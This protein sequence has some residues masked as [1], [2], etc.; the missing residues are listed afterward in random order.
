MVLKWREKK[1]DAQATSLYF[2]QSVFA[3]VS[4]DTILSPPH[5]Y[6]PY[7]SHISFSL[8]FE[9][10]V[11]AYSQICCVDSGQRFVKRIIMSYLWPC[12]FYEAL[13]IVQLNCVHIALLHT[14]L[15]LG[16]YRLIVHLFPMQFARPILIRIHSSKRYIRKHFQGKFIFSRFRCTSFFTNALH[17]SQNVN[18]FACID[19]GMHYFNEVSSI[20]FAWFQFY[21]NG[22]GV[23]TMQP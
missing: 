18:R 1:T 19:Y 15:W 5:S 7:P 4:H 6:S 10:G 12:S 2:N 13:C 16:I 11:Q 17:F 9:I 23:R 21:A 14:S 3:F 8:Y 20:A 22:A